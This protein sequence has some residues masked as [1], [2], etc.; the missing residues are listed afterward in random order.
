MSFYATSQWLTKLYDVPVRIL[1]E[2]KINR[3][4]ARNIEI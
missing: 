3:P 2:L 4:R 1:V